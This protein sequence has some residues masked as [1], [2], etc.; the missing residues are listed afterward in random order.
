MK[1]HSCAM[2]GQE[3]AATQ[4]RNYIQI[5]VPITSISFEF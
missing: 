3:A 2:T 1:S 4:V 5:F